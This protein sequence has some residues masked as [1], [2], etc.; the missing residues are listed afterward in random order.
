MLALE[1]GDEIGHGGRFPL[2]FMLATGV[3]TRIDQPAQPLGLGAGRTGR[4]VA[5]LSDGDAALLAAALDPVVEDEGPGTGSSDPAAKPGDVVI[6]CNG[7]TGGG[8][9]Q[10]PD[11][12]IGQARPTGRIIADTQQRRFRSRLFARVPARLASALT[13]ATLLDIPKS[14]RVSTMSAPKSAERVQP[15]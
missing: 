5:D 10:P 1:A 13:L 8:Q 14:S 3:C 4:P 9:G 15:M 2:V 11:G 7:V 12:R 6:P